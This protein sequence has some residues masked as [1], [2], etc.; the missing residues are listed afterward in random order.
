[1]PA[2]ITALPTPPST[3]DPTNFNTRADAFLG[4]LPAFVTQANTVAG[5]VSTSATQVAADR[6]QT[7][8]DRVAAAASAA[9]ALAAPGT[10][11]T[12]ATSLTIGVGSKSLTLDQT[13]KAFTL[14]QRVSIAI[15]ATPTNRMSG[16]ITAFNSSS[17]AMTVSVDYVPAGASGSASAWTLGL[18][19]QPG[20]SVA[21]FTGVRTL[22]ATDVVAISDMGKVL[23]ATGN[24]SLTMLVASSA[25]A[26]SSVLIKNDTAS[27]V[28]TITR[29]GSD[30]LDGLTSYK[31]YPG[32]A[33]LFEPATASTWI[34]Q[35][36]TPF[37]MVWTTS[38]AA[39]VWPPGYLAFAGEG[40]GAGGRGGDMSGGT[41]GSGGSGAPCIPYTILASAVTI[42]TS[43]TVTVG[44][45]NGANSD[46]ASLVGF[47]GGVAGSNITNNTLARKWDGTTANNGSIDELFSG[48]L[49][50]A[51]GP[52]QPGQGSLL[53]GG[54]G[55]GGG[56][57]GGSGGL[58]KKGGRGGDGGGNSL[59]P[60]AGSAPG[61]GGGGA[62]TF[63]YTTGANG[64][65]GEVRMQGMV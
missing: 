54:G 20:G 17:G 22:A 26:A 36:I 30:T 16:V 48:G 43:A 14:G 47:P 25:V 34:S 21:G 65:R 10:N 63:T 46:L 59:A 29:A 7:S 40:W 19:A 42:G 8:A 45:S 1:V 51:A 58:S 52:G 12:S 41:S 61:G 56:S 4:A 27:N 62:A 11:A 6:I 5:E 24:V 44:A 39:F 15:T 13:G 49:P 60:Q 55:G 53:G 28:I 18:D 33:R 64:A 3:N 31:I 38:D 37:Y 2:Q 23:R 35:V 50:G 9:S 57:S 32:E